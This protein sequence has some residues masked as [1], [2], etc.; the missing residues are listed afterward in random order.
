MRRSKKLKGY[1]KFKDED[2]VVE[3]K[4]MPADILP[5]NMLWIWATRLTSMKALASICTTLILLALVSMPKWITFNAPEATEVCKG[6]KWLKTMLPDEEKNDKHQRLY[7]NYIGAE[8]FPKLYGPNSPDD[9]CVIVQ[10]F[11]LRVYIHLVKVD[12]NPL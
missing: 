7:L 2:E 1:L 11:N 5:E 10:G 8:V 12:A 6:K 4:R 3:T 9:V